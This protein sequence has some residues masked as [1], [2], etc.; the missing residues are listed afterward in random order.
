MVIRASSGRDIES[1]IADLS[2]EQAITRDAAVARLTVIGA[3]SAVRLLALARNAHASTTARVGALRALE[4]IGEPR[5]LAIALGLFD[6][7]DAAL[8]M[9]AVAIAR[10]RLHDDTGVAVLDKL[11]GLALNLHRATL[12]RLAAIQALGDLPAST[13][14]P[15]FAALAHDPDAAVAA[16]ATGDS[17]ATP[18]GARAVLLA[19]AGGALPENGARLKSA[20]AQAA[21]AVPLTTLQQVVERAR[22]VEQAAADDAK[23]EWSA[24]RGAA[25]VALADRGSRL[26][27]YDLRE[28]IAAARTPLAV[29]F[30]AALTRLGDPSCLEAVAAAFA[31]APAA[32][33]DDWWRRSLRDTF[34][35]I[36]ERH[37]VTKRHATMKRIA[38]RWPLEFEAL[39]N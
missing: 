26:A 8:A 35:A 2:S 25:H 23:A 13:V 28:T 9:A 6:H 21:R 4:G 31:Q 39:H 27:L 29:D 18:D 19:A 37:G 14:A 16:A 1:L 38:K 12:V 3:R 33:H 15:V 7:D 17:S 22:D 20:L 11:T 32:G 34:R 24:A 36:L 5:I 10:D 30:I